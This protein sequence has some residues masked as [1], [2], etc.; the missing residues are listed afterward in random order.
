MLRVMRNCSKNDVMHMACGI[1]TVN[2]GQFT[3]VE[4][5]HG[6][7]V[8]IKRHF[9]LGHAEKVKTYFF[10]RLD[11]FE[12]GIW[13]TSQINSNQKGDPSKVAFAVF[14]ITDAVCKVSQHV[15]LH[16][17]FLKNIHTLQNQ[18]HARRL[19]LTFQMIDQFC[20]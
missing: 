7:G 19:I 1:G 17:S 4:G 20:R 12:F 16:L 8:S 13:K 15:P 2:V 11:G 14:L 10:Y 9:T 18:T 6:K 3:V 5:I